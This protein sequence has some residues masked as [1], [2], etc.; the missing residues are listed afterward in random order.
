MASSFVL[1]TFVVSSVPVTPCSG[2]KIASNDTPGAPARTSIVRL[3]EESKPVWF[4]TSPI[5][6]WPR[7]D[8]LMMK[9][10]LLEHIDTGFTAP[11]RVD[12]RR[13][14]LCASLYPV[15]LTQRR[16]SFSGGVRDRAFADR[17]GNFRSQSYR[18]SLAARMAR[19]AFVSS[20]MYVF[21]VGSIHNDVPVP[22]RY[23]RM[24]QQE[25]VH[26]DCLKTASRCPSRI[27]APRPRSE[28]VE[29][30]SSSQPQGAKEIRSRRSASAVRTRQDRSLSRTGR[31]GQ[32]LRPCAV[33]SDRAPRHAAS[34][35]HRQ[36]LSGLSS[37]AR[38]K[39]EDTRTRHLQ[40]AE[41]AL[42][43][44]ILQG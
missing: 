23:A 13:A 18:T 27:R 3:P 17:G 20:T 41:H 32:P 21:V 31:H 22:N 5:L 26:H 30:L 9:G 34:A 15:K 2:L 14:P 43:D 42:L 39:E 29:V 28:V 8:P 40:R 7:L 4:V 6:S 38:P 36:T 19:S 1:L 44:I 24:I 10:F 33:P 25:A 11:F 35:C 16:S 12:S 37:R